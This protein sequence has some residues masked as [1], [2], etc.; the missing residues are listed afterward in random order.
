[1]SLKTDKRVLGPGLAGMFVGSEGRRNTVSWRLDVRDDV[2]GGEL[3][4]KGQSTFASSGRP[5]KLFHY[6]SAGG[7]R[8]LRRTSADDLMDIRRRS[9]LMF[10]GAMAIFWIVF[11]LLP[12]A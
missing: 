1:M 4:G 12:C 10:L 9:F 3:F 7:M 5:R 8:Q 11:Y 6:I 2:R